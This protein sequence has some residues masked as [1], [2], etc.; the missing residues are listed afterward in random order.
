MQSKQIENHQQ[1]VINIS[2]QNMIKRQ[3]SIRSQGL[4][5]RLWLLDVA[6]TEIREHYWHIL[7][8][9]F[10]SKLGMSNKKVESEKEEIEVISLKKERRSESHL[11]GRKVQ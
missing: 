8:N 4:L 9:K 10:I 6:T 7:Y 2:R 5:L 11:Q 1:I 3:G